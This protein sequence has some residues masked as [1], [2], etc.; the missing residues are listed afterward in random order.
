M[1]ITCFYYLGNPETW[2]EDPTF[3]C[4]EMYVERGEEGDT[5]EHF[6]DTL[7]FQ[8]YTFRYIQKEFIEARRPLVGRSVMIVP[9][10]DEEWMMEFLSAHADSLSEWGTP[11]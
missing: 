6:Q 1:I 5:V 3:G 2:D 8:V 9:T 4:T 10:L 7:A 11:K